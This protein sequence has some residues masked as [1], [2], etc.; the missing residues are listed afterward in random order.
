MQMRGMEMHRWGGHG[1]G[2]GMG[3]GLAR[4][5]NNPKL[6][7][8][9]GITA[10]QAAKIRQEALD[11]QKAEIRSRADLQVNRLELHSLLSAETP[12]RAAIDKTLQQV[13]AA[14]F[15][16][17]KAGVEHQLAMSSLLTPAQMQ[18]LQE[19]RHEFGPGA[20]PRGQRGMMRPGGRMMR[21]GPGTQ[22]SAPPSP[23]PQ[24]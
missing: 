1:M 8:Q 20:G 23:S 16:M 3:M 11:F 22:Q 15:A 14:Q 21:R 12:D 24:Q 7:E 17:E 18:K 10:E 19:L 5:V 2:M 4:L 13:N 9:L 6:R